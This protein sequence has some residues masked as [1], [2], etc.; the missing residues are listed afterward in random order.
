M[1]VL[2]DSESSDS[3]TGRRFKTEATRA[4]NDFSVKKHND[5]FSAT[6][7]RKDYRRYSKSRSRS[8][9]HSRSRDRNVRKRSR[10]RD[11]THRRHDKYENPEKSSKRRDSREQKHSE[12]RSRDKDKDKEK[13]KEKEK[14]KDRSSHHSSSSKSSEKHKNDSSQKKSHSKSGSHE[15]NSSKQKSQS[16][17]RTSDSS[18]KSKRHKR[19]KEKIH[20][21]NSKKSTGNSEHRR[22]IDKQLEMADS[23]IGPNHDTH[24]SNDDNNGKAET[25]TNVEESLVCGPS[26]PP[27]MMGSDQKVDAMETKSTKPEKTYGPSLP[28]DFATNSKYEYKNDST[29]V[30]VSDNEDDDDDDDDDNE[31]IGPVLDHISNKSEAYLELE[32]RALEI[33][34]AKLSERE[35]KN[36]S[37]R[38]REE[39]MTE[40]PELR[41]VT[42]LG[43]TAR[44]FRTKER[45]EIKDRSSWTETPRD[46]EEKS[47]KKGPSHDDEVKV[48]H[49]KTERM[50]RERRD[51]EQEEAVRKHKKKHKRDE[52]LLEMHQKKLKK[53]S[54]KE[55]E[56]LER[57]PFSRDTDLQVN[58][59]DEAQKKS[60]LK[61]AQLLDTRFSS[62]QSK[63]L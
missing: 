19:S 48:R 39:W 56:P 37:I 53:K 21:D 59:F 29:I 41:T 13:E 43:L 61:K 52:S 60:I 42:D 25:E 20:E 11:R 22:S 28:S 57:R 24:D 35:K 58:R 14:E 9:S 49:Q 26:L 55:T 7:A 6:N 51:A 40:L 36:D 63:F 54:Q 27:H 31:L 4:R 23:A 3:D 38:G 8:R 34:L 1:N 47:K 15:T 5:S 17:E 50:H 45:D 30:D 2:S 10:S 16:R 32:K 46:R 44:Q 62:G 33:K 18:D 12:S